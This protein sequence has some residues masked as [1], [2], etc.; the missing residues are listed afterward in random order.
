L[1]FHVFPPFDAT[2]YWRGDSRFDVAV[3]DPLGESL[4]REVNRESHGYPASWWCSKI[5][6]V[7][8]I[9][10]GIAIQTSPG[11]KVLVTGPLN[12]F[13]EVFWVHSGVMDSDWFWI[14]NTINLQVVQKDQPFELTTTQPIAQ[15]I[16]IDSGI[17]DEPTQNLEYESVPEIACQWEK[18]LSAVYGQH[19]FGTHDVERVNCG[20]Y[21]K[22]KK[23]AEAFGTK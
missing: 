2:I 22:W 17:Q 10:P 23:Q 6:G 19:G 4:W 21:A 5:P 16:L 9:D 20:V 11:R 1:G 18:Y 8:Q 12:H 15:L 13:S 3:S 7:F 14:P